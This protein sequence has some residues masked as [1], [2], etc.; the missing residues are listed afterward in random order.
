MER[1]RDGEGTE[2]EGK[3]GDGKR[4][5]EGNINWGEGEVW[6]ICFWGIESPIYHDIS[7]SFAPP[8]LEKIRD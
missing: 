2:G 6:V 8:L 1:V 7:V 5:G 4:E 3:E